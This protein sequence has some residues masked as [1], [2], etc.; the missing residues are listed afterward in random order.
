MKASSL[1]ILGIDPGIN[2]TGWSVGSFDSVSDKLSV[3]MF[4]EIQAHNLAKKELKKDFR[5]YGSLVSL[6]LY[7]REFEAL[8][9][10][11]DPDYVASEDAFYNPRTPNAYLSLKLC[12]HTIQRV[13]YRRSKRL[14]L[15]APTVAKQAVWGKGTANKLA[16]QESI[17][18]LPDI[19]IRS[20][21][22]RPIDEME[23]HEAD[24]IAIMYAFTKVVL[25]DLLMQEKKK[26]K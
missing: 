2:H 8:L 13:L 17:Q 5:E 24:S 7:E 18:T 15:I 23:E 3:S 9:D 1:R 6:T 26:E 20:T 4:D 14:Y 22:L 11:Y 10:H 16:I 19:T 21:K 25:P 12:I